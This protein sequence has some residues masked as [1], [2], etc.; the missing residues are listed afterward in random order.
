M[1]LLPQFLQLWLERQV[2]GESAIDSRQ[3]LSPCV[4]SLFS[5]S[6]NSQCLSPA[7]YLRPQA[8]SNTEYVWATLHNHRNEQPSSSCSTASPAKIKIPHPGPRPP[9]Y[10][11]IKVEILG[12]GYSD[13][14]GTFEN[15][16][17]ASLPKHVFSVVPQNQSRKSASARV[18]YLTSVDA[19]NL[20]KV[21]PQTV[22]ESLVEGKPFLRSQSRIET[23]GE[24]YL[25][26]DSTRMK[27]NR[28]YK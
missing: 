13:D 26:D 16:P 24:S 4:S 17:L 8:R 7:L 1:K 11:R 15:A 27:M 23:I 5:P 2:H 12:E 3:M 18:I 10:K 14:E 21:R 22:D 20:E 25:R 9:K 28:L 6:F 19:L